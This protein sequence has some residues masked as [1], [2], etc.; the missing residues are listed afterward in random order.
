MP[1]DE[2]DPEPTRKLFPV[3]ADRIYLQHAGLS[4]ASTRMRD[5]VA[6]VGD[7]MSSSVGGRT[8]GAEWEKLRSDL[9]TLV[10]A[11]A[12]EI[13][14][15][16][17]TGHAISIASR[18]IDWQPGD[19]VVSIRME[20][21][22]NVFP[23]TA[24]GRHGVEL[25]LV[26]RVDGRVDVESLMAQVDDRTRVVAVS[27]IQFSNG[28]RLDLA[29]LGA[30]CRERGVLLVADAIQ[31]VG[32]IRLDV[33]AANVD[34]LACGASKWL[35]GPPGVGFAYV[36]AGIMDELLPPLAGGGTFQIR[37]GEPFEDLLDFQP[38]A[39]RYEESAIS[40]FDIA[41]M[42]SGLD[43]LSDAGTP[44]QIERRVLGLARGLGERLASMGYAMVEPWPR[45]EAESSAIVSIRPKMPAADAV[46]LLGDNGID[47]RLFRDSMRFSTHFFNTEEELDRVVAFLEAN[48]AP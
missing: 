26:D 28:H 29:A 23:W 21:P 15:T 24:L 19:N 12:D 27:W 32:A 43:I 9:A 45:T 48:V 38:T 2:L 14:L 40:W 20:F 8:Y 3:V 35:L 25:R 11:T 22:T 41:A 33:V 44:E 16:R 5:A 31:G 36:R 39:R 34:V 47:V 42:Q 46:K 17:G 4:L 10:G 30:A 1:L 37:V 13:T 7:D 6:R 18:G